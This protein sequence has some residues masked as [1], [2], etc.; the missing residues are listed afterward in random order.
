MIVAERPVDEAQRLLSLQALQV[1]DT[2][3][4]PAFDALVKSASLVCDT[5]IALLSLVDEDRQWFKANQGLPGV[6]QTPR[7]QA[8]CAHAI[9]SHHPLVVPNALKDKRFADNP[10][11]V[12][13]PHIR[14]YA[15]FPLALA[16]GALVGTLCV[17][18]TQPRSLNST[19]IAVLEQLAQAAA[20]ALQLRVDQR[21]LR[22]LLA[23]QE[24]AEARLKVILEQ[25]PLGVFVT[26]ANGQCTYTN[27]RWQS[28][29]GVNGPDSLGDGWTKALTPTTRASVFSAWAEAATTGAEF[30]MEFPVND[31]QGRGATVHCRARPLR[32]RQ[33]T[34]TGY[35]GMVSDVSDRVDAQRAQQ[36]Q[37]A[38]LAAAVDALNEGFVLL[39]P[40]KR[41]LMCNRVY[42]EIY[43]LSEAEF[44]LG[45]SYESILRHGLS[46]KSYPTAVGREAAWLQERLG[47]R[48]EPRFEAERHLDG[49]RTLRVVDQQLPDGHAVGVRVDITD[50]VKAREGAEAALRAKSD[51]LANMSHEVRTPLNAVSGML[52][53]LRQTPLSSQQAQYLSRAE[54][55]MGQQVTLLDD[56]LDLIRID[57][58]QVNVQLAPLSLDQLLD[59]L[60][61]V[62]SPVAADKSLELVFCS[63][64]GMP[65]QLV[66]DARRVRQV[67]GCLV[68]NAIKFTDRGEV[69]LSLS[70]QT[71]VQDTARRQTLCMVVEDTGPGIAADR[72]DAIFEPFNQGSSGAAR[73][74][75]GAGLGLPLARGLV[76]ALGGSLQVSS[77]LGVGSRFSVHVPVQD[78]VG[79]QPGEAAALR[80]LLCDP[81]P[82]VAQAM[83]AMAEDLKWSVACE[84]SAGPYSSQNE[85][86]LQHQPQLVVCD[87][88]VLNHALSHPAWQAWSPEDAT[89]LVM[90]C[91]RGAA[92][93]GAP[94]MDPETGRVLISKP[95]TRQRLL[96]AVRLAHDATAPQPTQQR[97]EPLGGV[98]QGLRILLV[99]DNPDNQYVAT[100]L[101]GGAGAQ[102]VVAVDGLD[103]LHRLSHATQ[104]PDLVLMDMQMPVMDGLEATRRLRAMPHLQSLP[105]VAL[106]ANA[107]AF[108]RQQCLDAGMSDHVGK[109]FHLPDLLRTILDHTQGEKRI[110]ARSDQPAPEPNSGLPIELAATLGVDMI[111]ALTRVGGDEELYLELLDRLIED[112]RGMPDQLRMTLTHDDV[113]QASRLMHAL[114]GSAGTLGV[115]ALYE[116]AAQAERELAAGP[117]GPAAMGIAERSV[118]IILSSQRKLEDLRASCLAASQPAVDANV[119]SLQIDDLQELRRLLLENDLGALDA[120]STLNLQHADRAQP[121]GAALHAAVRN[122]DFLAAVQALDGLEAQQ[123]GAAT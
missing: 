93:G 101:L 116:S 49:G 91:S 23:R 37:H 4:E 78:C 72:L 99:E 21:G 71:R 73:N 68:G 63:A 46:R 41:L 117:T 92:A 74:F 67:L 27:E 106:T 77:E 44:P 38:L 16:D 81:S 13:E 122:L 119:S 88:S 94:V 25:S 28:I 121:W 5:P 114:K 36:E 84:G 87:E 75:G 85:S 53:A 35:V 40:A 58:G 50:L 17:I 52:T 34:V 59:D 24:E 1:L 31:H 10:L 62:M 12:G 26:D 45:C 39:D 55:A 112:L 109:P 6:C 123:R 69:R 11:V 83:V 118:A 102:V 113:R 95:L 66:S 105:I 108:D 14:F 65:D 15:G 3:P 32:D 18:D 51:F 56:I 2:V 54:R 98:L 103:A 47:Q 86:V 33:G 96:A 42:R 80:V 8:F 120:M 9:L 110:S 60:G 22:A 100:E 70:V 20:A 111:G 90:T 61:E 57:N 107:S 64:P 104:L 97:A 19:Q 29:Y 48:D 43:G 76:Q 7:S 79:W 89:W 30:N 82:G 115:L